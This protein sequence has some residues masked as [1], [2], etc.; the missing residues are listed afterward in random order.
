M[1]QKATSMIGLVVFRKNIDPDYFNLTL[2]LVAYQNFQALLSGGP[3]SGKNHPQRRLV[4]HFK[5]HMTT[6]S[7][8]PLFADFCP[9]WTDAIAYSESL[10]EIMLFAFPSSQSK[11]C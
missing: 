11:K 5:L 3:A 9:A 4:F 7:F 10:P 1:L 8:L 2:A 6:F